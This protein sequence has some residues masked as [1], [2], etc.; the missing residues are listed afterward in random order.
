M[1]LRDLLSLEF[2]CHQRCGTTEKMPLPFTVKGRNLVSQSANPLI[3][4]K[5]LQVSNISVL[6]LATALE[7]CQGL[8]SI[9]LDNQALKWSFLC[10]LKM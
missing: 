5:A 3:S 4:A 8:F 9:C 10:L 2:F 1:S 6:V 7:A